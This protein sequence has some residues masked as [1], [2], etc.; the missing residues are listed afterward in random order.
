ME[1][2]EA[3]TVFLKVFLSEVNIIVGV[4]FTNW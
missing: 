4:I 2:W 1:S 3:L